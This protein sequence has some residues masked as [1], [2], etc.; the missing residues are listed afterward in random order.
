MG[1]KE[2]TRVGELVVSSFD[3]MAGKPKKKIK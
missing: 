3:N 2:Q 1:K